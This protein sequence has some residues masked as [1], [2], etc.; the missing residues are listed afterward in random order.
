M[1]ALEAAPMHKDLYLLMGRILFDCL[2]RRTYALC[3]AF[4]LYTSGVLPF[5]EA[6]SVICEV[7]RYALGLGLGK[8]CVTTSV[9]RLVARCKS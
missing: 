2:V 6:S 5:L 8:Q 1:M 7:L 3:G 9:F 4:V